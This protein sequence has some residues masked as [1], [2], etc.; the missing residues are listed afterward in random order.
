M[1]NN[2]ELDNLSFYSSDE[3]AEGYFNVDEYSEELKQ[4]IW[5][6]Q[7]LSNKRNL[8]EDER[9]ERAEIRLELKN[10]STSM[11]KDIKSMIEDME[12]SRRK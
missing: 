1:E 5:R 10:V 11:A 12:S 4:K 3:V 2:V 9:A 6:Y 8:S 7:Q